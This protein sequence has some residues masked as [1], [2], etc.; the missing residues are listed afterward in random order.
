MRVFDLRTEDGQPY[1]FEVENLWLRQ[2]GAIDVVRSTPGVSVSPADPNRFDDE[3][4]VFELNGVI[5]AMSEPFGDNSRYWVGPV[6]AGHEAELAI[7]RQ[8]FLA[9]RRPEW[10]SA[11]LFSALLLAWLGSSWL[12]WWGKAPRGTVVISTPMA[13][14]GAVALIAGAM[15]AGSWLLR[16]L[17]GHYRSRVVEELPPMSF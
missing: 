13:G 16:L 14:L 12:G 9:L 6:E 10:I 3:F 17:S 7:V 4:C 2:A 15:I 11:R 1:A 5:F 8:A